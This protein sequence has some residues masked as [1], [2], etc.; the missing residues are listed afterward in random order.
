MGPTV[1]YIG[2][3]RVGKPIAANI[4]KAGFPLTVYDIQEAPAPRAGRAGGSRRQL[5]AEVA[6]NAEIVEL[7][8][9]D[10]VQVRQV[11]LGDDGILAGAKDELHRRHP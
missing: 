8:V 3:G 9:V 11:L 10:D 5:T 7:S 4:L 6:E 1:G 2:V